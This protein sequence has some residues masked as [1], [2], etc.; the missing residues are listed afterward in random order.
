VVTRTSSLAVLPID[1]STTA[2]QTLSDIVYTCNNPAGFTRT[3][4]SAE[5]GFMRH[6]GGTETIEY[7]I[8]HSGG[9]LATPGLISLATP[10]VSSHT[11]SSAYALGRTATLRLAM[12]KIY[13][14]LLAGKYVDTIT[15]TI[16]GN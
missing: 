5:G 9:D 4:S 11:A 10:Y 3:I 13:N 15:I 12:R 14:D 1:L 7:R 2:S 16:V 8:A 6:V